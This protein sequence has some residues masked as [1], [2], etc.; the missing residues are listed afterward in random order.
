M[1]GT[2]KFN[3]LFTVEKRKLVP[4]ELMVSVQNSTRSLNFMVITGIV[5]QTSFLTK[6]LCTQPSKIK[7]I[8]P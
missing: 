8:S 7:T 1:D 2:L 4:I 3:L 5:I 6:M